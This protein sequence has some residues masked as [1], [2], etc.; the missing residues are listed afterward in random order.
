MRGV[1][2]GFHE[3]IRFI[4]N[5]E[6]AVSL[7]PRSTDPVYGPILEE[8]LAA[9]ETQVGEIERAIPRLERLLTTPYGSFPL[10]QARLRLDPVWDPLRSH[11]RFK[12]LVAGPEPK[13]IYD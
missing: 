1:A 5:A 8:D 3:Q 2:M 13:T 12:A 4:E 6:R 10:S 11:P 9:V 7:L